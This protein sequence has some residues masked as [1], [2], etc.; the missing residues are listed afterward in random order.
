MYSP[1]IKPEL[2][3]ILYTIAKEAKKPMTV[4][5]SEIIEDYIDSKTDKIVV[6]VEVVSKKKVNVS[7][8]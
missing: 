7:K 2:I 6:N 1:K 5:V 4:V 3:P 8:N